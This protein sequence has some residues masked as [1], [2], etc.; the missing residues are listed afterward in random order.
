MRTILPTMAGSIGVL[1]TLVNIVMT[2]VPMFLIDE[3]RVGRRNLMVGSALVMSLSSFVLGTAIVAGY[4]VLAAVS[5]SV[6][7]AGFALGLGPIP[8]VILPEL[9]PSRAVSAATSLGLT[10]NWTANFIVGSAFLPLRTW[11]SDWDTHHTGGSV[12]YIFAVINFV[13]ALLVYKTYRYT[14]TP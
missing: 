7:V 2:F 1:I 4:K 11:L 3:A 5:L 9:V 13:T 12:F 6:F 14:P 10:L 8:F